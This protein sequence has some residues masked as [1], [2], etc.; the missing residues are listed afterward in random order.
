[1]YTCRFF[2]KINVNDKANLIPNLKFIIRIKKDER[3]K[4]LRMEP[5]T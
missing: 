1:M 2:L 5:H 4:G 3:C